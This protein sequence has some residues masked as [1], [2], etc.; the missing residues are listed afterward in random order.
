MGIEIAI[1]LS[2]FKEGE[3]LTA[4]GLYNKKQRIVVDLKTF[5]QD[6]GC[7]LGHSITPFTRA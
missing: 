5:V 3:V 6:L 1:Q 4:A 2:H 7:R